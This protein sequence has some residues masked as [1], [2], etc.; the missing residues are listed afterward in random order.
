VISAQR[1]VQNAVFA[2]EKL[3]GWALRL[4]DCRRRSPLTLYMYICVP[5][6]PAHLTRRDD[7]ASS[8]GIAGRPLTG[9]FASVPLFTRREHHAAHVLFPTHPRK[10][11]NRF[12][13]GKNRKEYSFLAACQKARERRDCARAPISYRLVRSGIRS[14]Y[15]RPRMHFSGRLPTFDHPRTRHQRAVRAD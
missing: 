11:I 1:S 3:Y 7:A 2:L 13:C 10:P 4:N 5:A 12:R 9:A 8:Q 14:L 6:E 15:F